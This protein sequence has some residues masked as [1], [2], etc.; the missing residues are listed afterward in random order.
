MRYKIL[1]M[2]YFARKI[3]RGFEVREYRRL[4]RRWRGIVGFSKEDCNLFSEVKRLTDRRIPLYLTENYTCLR[5][6]R[7][8][9]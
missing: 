1:Y 4:L 9:K 6:D 5:F 8:I 2:E 7:G 3:K